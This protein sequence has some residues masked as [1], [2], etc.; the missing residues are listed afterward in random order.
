MDS[1]NNRLPA[2]AGK[3]LLRLPP[4]LLVMPN[5]DRRYTA[6]RAGDIRVAFAMRDALRDYGE[7][8][9]QLTEGTK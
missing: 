5:G 8:L 6:G 7:G 2:D 3:S 4:S 1:E 9:H